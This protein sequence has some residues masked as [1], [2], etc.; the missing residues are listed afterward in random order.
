MKTE[1]ESH[2]IIVQEGKVIEDAKESAENARLFWLIESKDYG[3][4]FRIIARTPELAIS[5]AESLAMD[6]RKYDEVRA[7]AAYRRQTGIGILT[8]YSRNKNEPPTRLNCGDIIEGV[9]LVQP[10]PRPYPLETV[11]EMMKK[12]TT[13][14]TTPGNPHVRHRNPFDNFGPDITPG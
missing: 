12:L 8:I 7:W 5:S 6:V 9:P 10:A 1:T 11:E 14:E 13:W 2:A 4:R 3:I